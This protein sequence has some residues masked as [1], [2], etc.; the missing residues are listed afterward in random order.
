MFSSHT[1]KFDSVLK[2]CEGAV[3]VPELSTAFLSC[4]PGRDKWNTVLGVLPK[5]REGI[6]DGAIWAY[7]YGLDNE[8]EEQNDSRVLQQITLQGFDTTGF[9]PLGIDYHAPSRRLFVVSHHYDCSRIE[10][11][12]LDN[13][14]DPGESTPLPIIAKHVKTFIQREHLP[15]PNSI[16]VIND[17][18]L[19]VTRDHKYSMRDHPTLASFE[20]SYRFPFGSV[21]YV[22]LETDK[23]QEVASVPYANGITFLDSTWLAVASTSTA[24]VYFFEVNPKGYDR[25]LLTRSNAHFKFFPDNV[26]AD[27]NGTLYIAGHADM[28]KLEA[29]AED[30]RHST[31]HEDPRS[32]TKAPTWVSAWTPGRNVR[33]L[34]VTNHE[35]GTGSTAAR[36]SVKN[37]G[38][39]T[40][41]YERGILVWKM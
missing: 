35:F 9:H 14:P 18:E 20:T 33:D 40:G 15:T 29:V 37:I 5:N 8:Q 1:I 16:A 32:Y 7:L 30:R 34:Y 11:F 21:L 4:D 13:L 6:P 27:K 10:T 24:S 23:M 2:N 3:V 25:Q 28:E 17:H 26:S 22:N 41:L 12:E 31:G 38:I 19:Y 36:D 39:I